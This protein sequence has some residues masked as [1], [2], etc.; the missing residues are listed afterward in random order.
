MILWV[1]IAAVG[2]LQI[3]FQTTT[4]REESG[5]DLNN[6]I[7]VYRSEAKD[8][9][10]FLSSYQSGDV[11]FERYVNTDYAGSLDGASYWFLI[12]EDLLKAFIDGHQDSMNLIEIGKPQLDAFTVFFINKNQEVVVEKDYGRQLPFDQRDYNHRRYY[13]DIDNPEDISAIL[14]HVKTSSYLQ[15]PVKLWH[16]SEWIDVLSD[17]MIGHGLFYGALLIMLLYNIILGISIRDRNYIYFSLFIL[18][19]GMMQAIWDGFAFQFLWPN[20]GSWDLQ[21]NPVIINIVSFSL[22]GFTMNFMKVSRRTRW[23]KLTY[24]ISYVM[25]GLAVVMVFIVSSS[26]SVYLAMFNALSTLLLSLIAII[27]K[28]FSSRAEVLYMLAWQFFLATNTLNILAG[29]KLIPYT[30]V[31]EVSPKIA[32]IGLIALFSLALSEKLNTV[33]YLRG[34]EEEKRTLLKNLHEMHV[35]IS[36]TR[37][38]QAVFDYLLDMFY[39]ITRY[40]DGIIVIF[41]SEHKELDYF[42]KRSGTID[43]LWVNETFYDSIYKEIAESESGSFEE[44]KSLGFLSEHRWKSTDIIPLINLNHPIGFI[45]LGSKGSAAIDFATREA[46]N[47][48]ATQIAVTIDNKRLLDNVTYQARHDFLT[49]AITEGTSLNVLRSYMIQWQKMKLLVLS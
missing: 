5:Y 1:A 18:S 21:S 7:M 23:L 28:E 10:A 37:E 39:S 27:R 17:D 3:P 12:E 4:I 47:D 41:D 42:D 6:E 40:E 25:H 48:F 30:R 45:V 36:S 8:I 32:I 44:T 20:N 46:I 24:N 14:F 31:T 43:R 9:P 49:K 11:S 22:L 29:M 38:M 2:L 26:V 16:E 13:I 35:K 33:E 15:F 19:Y 34:I